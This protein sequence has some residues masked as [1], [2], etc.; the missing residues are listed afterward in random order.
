MNHTPTLTPAAL[1]VEHTNSDCVSRER[2]GN[3]ISARIRFF[4]YRVVLLICFATLPAATS[5]SQTALAPLQSAKE[6]LERMNQAITAGEFKIARAYMTKQG[7]AEVIGDLAGIA[8]SLADPA[9]NASFPQAFDSYKSEF[10]SLLTAAGLTTEWELLNSDPAQFEKFKALEKSESGIKTLD[11]LLNA[12]AAMPWNGF[13][14]RGTAQTVF[15]RKQRVF[16]GIAPATGKEFEESGQIPVY[17]FVPLDG[18]WK[19]DGVSQKETLAYNEKL[20][21]LPPQLA[22]ASFSGETADG[23][24]ISLSQYRGKVVLF[25]FWGTWCAPCVKKLPQLEKIHAA[26]SPHGFEIIGVALD[27]AETL[28]EF[29]TTKT[30][31]W[32]NVVDGEGAIKEKFGVKKYPTIMLLD[33]DGQHIASNLEENELVDA[34]VKLL[35]L[36]AE[37][38]ESL[39]QNLVEK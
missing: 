23:Q 10:K 27:D 7:A 15:Q 35:G 33:Q 17:R 26:F 9:I 39:K 12:A 24:A 25:D 2:L 28:K 8:I 3:A 38:F 36:N 22:D 6:T 16:I 32:R 4:F 18:M 20:A 31:P 11:Q 14:F 37:E 29:Y 13:D 34:L 30:L 1:Q 19:F 21:T 5:W